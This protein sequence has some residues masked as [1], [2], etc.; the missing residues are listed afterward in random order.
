[1]R[2]AFQL[3]VSPASRGRSR[4]VVPYNLLIED[5]QFHCRAARRRARCRSTRRRSACACNCC[6]TAGCASAS[7]PAWA[8]WTTRRDA[9]AHGGDAA[10]A[11]RDQRLGQGR[12][13][14]MPSAR[15]R[16]GLRAAGDAHRR[17][18][19]SATSISCWPSA[20]ATARSRRR[21]MRYLRI[22]HVIQVDANADNLGRV[23]KPEVCVHA[24]AGVFLHK[25]HDCAGADLP[26]CQPR[27][28][29][30]DSPVESA[31]R[32]QVN[33][34]VL[35]ALRRRSDGVPPGAAACDL[36]GR[37]AVR[38]RDGVGTLGGGGVHGAASRGRIFNPTE[39]PGDG[40]VD[41]GGPRRPARP[42][43]P[44]GVTVT[45]DG[46]FLMSAHGDLDGGA[47]VPAGEVL[48]AGRPGVSLHAGVAAAG[49]PAHDGDDPGPA[50]TTRRWPRASASAIR[51]SSAPQDLEGGIRAAL[52]QPGPVLTRVVTDYG[53]R[54]MRWL[55]AAKG[56]SRRN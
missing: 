17:E 33:A 54:P 16:L 7:T 15:G 8:A 23:V 55:D 37:P 26:P 35:R 14:R 24:D 29:R 48:R 18:G 53:K 44:A 6:A 5:A 25:L 40:L 36:R 42:S 45:G 46:C 3:R 38:G 47:R 30:G 12:H 52:E 11:G 21:F 50:R 56:G 13:R 28:G 41:P 43:G 27:S 22:P 49:L 1:M 20:C 32:R 51:R 39:Q 4:V 31:T 10:G 9:G 2:Q 34:A 19:V